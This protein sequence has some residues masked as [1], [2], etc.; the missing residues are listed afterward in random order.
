MYQT[1][2]LKLVIEDHSQEPVEHHQ[3]SLVTQ[4]T[5]RKQELDFQVEQEE[6][7]QDFAEQWLES[8]LEVEELT[9]Q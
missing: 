3:L 2:K 4:M 9:S 1:V 5:E 8:L 6:L 7:Y